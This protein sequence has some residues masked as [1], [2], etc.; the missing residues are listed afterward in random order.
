MRNVVPGPVYDD[1]TDGRVVKEWSKVVWRA[2]KVSE[3]LLRFCRDSATAS[4]SVL[5]FEKSRPWSSWG[6]VYAAGRADC[7]TR[8]VGLYLVV[9]NADKQWGGGCS[10]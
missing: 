7:Y 1:E 9:M 10:R 3:Q 2:E 8:L 4:W 5:P 6:E